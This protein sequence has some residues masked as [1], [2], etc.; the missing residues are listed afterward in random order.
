MNVEAVIL[1]QIEYIDER[2]EKSLNNTKL[3]NNY[4]EK[5][6]MHQDQLRF[7]KSRLWNKKP[8]KKRND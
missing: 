6:E 7:A 1:R 3:L 4:I 5:L 8:T 2:I